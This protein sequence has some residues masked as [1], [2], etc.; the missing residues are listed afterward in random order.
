MFALFKKQR[1]YE[2]AARGVYGVILT[3]VR[4]P[5]FYE[6]Y[7]VPD[8]LDGRFDLLC[9]HIFLVMKRVQ[10]APS[11]QGGAAFNQA[12][13]DVF[14]ADMDQML[15]EMGVG[16]MGIPKRMR[17]MMTAFNG[18]M[19]V[20]AEALEDKKA[21]QESLTRNL[22]GGEANSVPVKTMAEYVLKQRAVL[23]QN[24]VVDILKGTLIMGDVVLKGYSN[25]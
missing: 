5:V 10:D 22:F 11:V 12:L 9:L 14:F 16:D 6:R 18:R 2:D 17:R 25:E 7:G 1:P 15:R 19:H 20:Y 3:H 23:Q 13:F 21:L 8:T 4:L 24:D